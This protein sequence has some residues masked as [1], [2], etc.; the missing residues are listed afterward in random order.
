M[1]QGF[2]L[3]YKF[4]SFFSPRCV[5]SSRDLTHVLFQNKE[6]GSG[7]A[8]VEKISNKES[9]EVTMGGKEME[10]KE[11]GS[12]LEQKLKKLER[13]TRACRLTTTKGEEAPKKKRKTW[14]Q[15][16]ELL[17]DQGCISC[18]PCSYPEL[19]EDHVL[20]SA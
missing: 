2:G 16:M 11:D 7:C 9:K 19:T 5:T 6:G 4:R 1:R 12:D 8:Q 20:P 3:L 10:R 17:W 15:E 18:G 13:A 14:K